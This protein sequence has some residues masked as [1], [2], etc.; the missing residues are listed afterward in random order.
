MRLEKFRRSL[1]HLHNPSPAMTMRMQRVTP[2]MT[3]EMPL[4]KRKQD[5]L[6]PS[7]HRA[8]ERNPARANLERPS[9]I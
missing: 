8:K 1:L 5:P 2:R 7:T 4:Q 6:T 3:E 9:L